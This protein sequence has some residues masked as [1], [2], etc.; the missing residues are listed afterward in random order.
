MLFRSHARLLNEYERAIDAL[1]A[2]YFDTEDYIKVNNLS[3]YDNSVMKGA[4]K[5]LALSEK[6]QS[7]GDRVTTH[8]VANRIVCSRCG[9]RRDDKN[10]HSYCPAVKLFRAQ[11]L[12]AP[13]KLSLAI[14]ETA[15]I[16]TKSTPAEA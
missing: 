4:R 13:A 9:T 11:H 3:G 6:K 12:W 8:N 7:Y 14:P 15:P 10:G 2:L 5:A 16:S 1:A